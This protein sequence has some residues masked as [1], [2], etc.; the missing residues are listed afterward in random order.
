M[1]Q[2]PIW[3]F[4]T[5]DT[6]FQ[7]ARCYMEIVSYRDRRTLRDV[8]NRKL[9]LNSLIHSDQSRCYCN[10]SQLVPACIQH[11]TVSYTY[12][13]VDP[14]TGAPTRVTNK[15]LLYDML[16][17]LPCYSLAFVDWYHDIHLVLVV[18]LLAINNF[19]CE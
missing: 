13:F 7:P 8:L 10:V 5:V 6:S 16:L 17:L 2:R 12:N 18:F 4:R 9:S 1:A 19:S 15:F 3:V 11:N 14:V